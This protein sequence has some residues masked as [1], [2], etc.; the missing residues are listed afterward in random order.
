VIIE[1]ARILKEEEKKAY[2]ARL[3]EKIRSMLIVSM[4]IEIAD[5]GTLERTSGGKARR[6]R[7]LE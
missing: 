2:A 3:R 7:I 4:N 5:P 1:S 6:V